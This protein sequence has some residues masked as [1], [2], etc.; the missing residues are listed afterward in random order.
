MDTTVT[1]KM[2]QVAR[3]P[4]HRM[5]LEPPLPITQRHTDLFTRKRGWDPIMHPGD[6]DGA[7]H[8]YGKAGH[9]FPVIL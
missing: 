3:L 4:R 8:R 6:E 7:G 9:L 5:Q 2:V 1:G